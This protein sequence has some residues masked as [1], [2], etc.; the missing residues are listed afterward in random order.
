MG[1]Q[2]VALMLKLLITKHISVFSLWQSHFKL[3]S[4]KKYN[5]HQQTKITFY[6]M[7]AF[8]VLLW[9][10]KENKTSVFCIM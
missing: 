7:D 3:I 8:I 4:N 6:M 2:H 10:F 5:Q 9:K 1:C